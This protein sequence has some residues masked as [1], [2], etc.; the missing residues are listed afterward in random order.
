MRMLAPICTG[1]SCSDAAR[2]GAPA[3]ASTVLMPTVRSSVLL[4]DMFEPLTS[5]HARLAGDLH[6][7]ANAH[8]GGDQGM[9]ESTCL[10]RRRPVDEFGKRVRNVLEGSTGRETAVPR[11]RPALRARSG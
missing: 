3:I 11:S 2:T 1:V 4:P 7:V 9:A 8:R 5:K 10:E 6:V